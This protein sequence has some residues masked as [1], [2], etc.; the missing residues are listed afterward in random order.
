[1]EEFWWG[2][3]GENYSHDIAAELP[4][5]RWLR[6]I[7]WGSG[8]CGHQ[9]RL[10]ARFKSRRPAGASWGFSS[11]NIPL[12]SSTG[13]FVDS[14]LFWKGSDKESLEVRIFGTF[15]FWVFKECLSWVILIFW[16][17]EA[18]YA[19]VWLRHPYWRESSFRDLPKHV[20]F[21]GGIASF[22]A[23]YLRQIREFDLSVACNLWLFL[24]LILYCH[25]FCIWSEN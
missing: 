25:E 21:P 10:R 11:P 3:R 17:C 12:R 23:F 2:A 6:N 22:Y 18:E 1:M 13:F 20:S 24:D 4:K 15:I 5:M 9:A 19:S 7:R 14:L 16:K 8:T